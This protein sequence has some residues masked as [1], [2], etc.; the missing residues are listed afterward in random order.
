MTDP[1]CSAPEKRPLGV[2]L[3]PNFYEALKDLPEATVGKLMLA[4]MRYTLYNEEP[5]FDPLLTVAWTFLKNYADMDRKRY[6]EAVERRRSAVEKRW[7]NERAKRSSSAEAPA[8]AP[9]PAPKSLSPTPPQSTDEDEPPASIEWVRENILSGKN[10]AFVAGWAK[11][12]Y[13]ELRENQ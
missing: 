7:K 4:L 6:C 3:Y 11:K 10:G 8:E 2:M 9:K 5:D 13:P 1:I 12:M